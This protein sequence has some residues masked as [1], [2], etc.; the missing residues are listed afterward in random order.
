MKF[1]FEARSSHAGHSYSAI[2]FP[3]VLGHYKLV[4]IQMKGGTVWKV[5]KLITV[6]S[7]FLQVLS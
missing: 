2:S 7:L 5:D 6:S 1:S 4:S 3:T